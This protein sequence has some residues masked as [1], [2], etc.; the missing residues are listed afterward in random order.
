MENNS[1]SP[2]SPAW[3]TRWPA[4]SFRTGPTLLLVLVVVGAS[5]IV[6]GL[7]ALALAPMLASGRVGLVPAVVVQLVL[8]VAILVVLLAG[9]PRVSRL[10]L[11]EL[12]FTRIAP[13]QIG[14]ALL[15]ALA[16]IVVVEGGASLIDTLT[17]T[18]HEQGVVEM[19]KSLHNPATIWFFAL[20][21]TVLAPIA[22]ETVFRVFLFNLGLRYGGF[23]MGATISGILF[24]L[25]HG[26]KFVL[27]P[28]ALGGMILCGVY[29]RTRNAYASMITHACFNAVTVI[30]LLLVPKLAS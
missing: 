12:G 5:A 29:Y 30:A 10:T 9:L 21:A 6:L 16:M 23:W 22:E 4:D 1:A 3:P 11:R 25:A 28:L 18:K 24:G 7:A 17:H 19:F 15:G 14:V 13:W 20:F 27:V 2:T 26:D 8:E